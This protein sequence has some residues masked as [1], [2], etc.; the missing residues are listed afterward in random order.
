M[1][2]HELSQLRRIVMALPEVNERTSH[3][4]PCFFVQNKIALCY[5]HDDHRGDERTTLWCPATEGERDALVASDQKRFFSPPTSS[6]GAFRNWVVMSL[7]SSAENSL[8]WG[9][10]AVLL[11]EVYCRVA[12][13]RLAAK[14]L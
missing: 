4:A 6:S 3:G 7:E 5:F 2:A 13:K 12:P 9:Q 14:V 11:R 8:D 10:V 1:A